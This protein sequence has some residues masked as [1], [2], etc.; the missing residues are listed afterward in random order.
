[1]QRIVVAAKAGDEQPWVADAA[2]RLANQTGA[3][4]DVVSVDG[5]DLEALS[6]LPRDEYAALA[7]QAVDD[8]VARLAQDGVEAT[9]AVR[10][11]R[12]AP[13]I[14]VYAEE[15]RADV[16]VCGASSRGRIATKLLGSVP[17]ELLEHSR[18]P[19]L[20]VTPPE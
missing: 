19:V 13:G 16:I 12:I 20:V 14:L 4:V 18:R 5:V 15:R 10:P 6:P 1:M 3:A 11:G 2:A 17:L 8:T 9:G 7:R